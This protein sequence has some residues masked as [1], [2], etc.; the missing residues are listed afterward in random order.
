MKKLL[1]LFALGLTMSS[2]NAQ[3]KQSI[4][5][6]RAKDMAGLRLV[7][8]PNKMQQNANKTTDRINGEW[9]CFS[10]AQFVDQFSSSVLAPVYPD[11]NIKSYAGNPPFYWYLHGMGT[12]FDPVSEKFYN[13]YL[14]PNPQYAA[15]TFRVQAV[16]PYLVDSIQVIGQ[17]F[18]HLNGSNVDTL[19]IEVV[20]TNTPGT[21]LV[22]WRYLGPIAGR[23]DSLLQVAE[24]V[25]SPQRNQIPSD[26]VPQVVRITKILNA[27]AAADT[28]ANGL[29]IW[30]FPLNIAV[31]AGEKVIAFAHFAPQVRY[32]VDAALDTANRWGHLSV[33][34]N[35]ST[36]TP[37]QVPGDWNG[38]LIASTDERYQVG[39]PYVLSNGRKVLA[40]SYAY[41]PRFLNDP[42][43]AFH[44][45]CPACTTS[46]KD[47]SN[48]SSVNAYPNPANSEVTI[49]YSLK[50]ATAAI[51]TVNITN[52]VGQVLASQKTS[53]GKVVF[54]T[55][56]LANGIYF[57]TVEANGQKITNRF[58]VGH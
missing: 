24:P 20:K 56:S 38:G 13:N 26:S 36:G 54:S 16:N 40:A 27:A 57:Y 9:F 6:P 33:A 41:T 46:V 48:F 4:L 44:I 12:S 8:L 47:V 17:Y 31:G 30:T 7:Q 22:T 25:Y 34:V 21:S 3:E 45:K 10:D 19:Y 51:A 42:W 15:P 11:S 29:S 28:D 1:L 35:G 43:F 2:V 5:S 37:N 55:S 52:A 39:N 49:T 50:T 23:P 58:V 53:N 14:N 18:R 32:A